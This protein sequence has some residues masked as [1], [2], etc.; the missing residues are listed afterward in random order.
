MASLLSGQVKGEPARTV[1]ARRMGTAP[2][3]GRTAPRGTTDSLCRPSLVLFVAQVPALAFGIC[4]GC[5]CQARGEQSVEVFEA[6]ASTS[7]LGSSLGLEVKLDYWLTRRCRIVNFS[8]YKCPS[9]CSD[10]V[11]ADPQRLSTRDR[12]LKF[13]LNSQTRLCTGPSPEQNLST[14]ALEICCPYSSQG[15]RQ[16]MAFA[17]V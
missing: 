14:T 2:T 13:R 7:G 4:G 8:P 16:I 17:Y 1:S 6:G 3:S 5:N 10:G 12:C 15:F 9:A 11:V